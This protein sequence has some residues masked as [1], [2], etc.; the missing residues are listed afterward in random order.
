MLAVVVAVEELSTATFQDQAAQVVVEQEVLL[1]EALLLQTELLV[2]LIQ[3]AVVVVLY[4]M[5]A[6][7]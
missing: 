1:A 7:T 5:E 2:P 3:V 6:L 4:L